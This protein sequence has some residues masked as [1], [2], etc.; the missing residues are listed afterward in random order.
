M[1]LGAAFITLVGALDD[2]FDLPPAAKLAG[3]VA[4][5]LIVVHYG[6]VVQEIALPFVGL[7][8]FPNAGAAITVV[9]LVALMNIVNFSDGVDGLAAGVCAIIALALA[10]IAFDLQRLGARRARRRSSPAPRWASCSTTSRPPPA[11]WATAAPT[12]SV[13]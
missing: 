13:C 7:L 8:H 5:A 4:A 2:R 12:C 9:G 6:I 3:Q 1:L 10:V 11:S